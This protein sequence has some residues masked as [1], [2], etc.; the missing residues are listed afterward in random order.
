MTILTHV[1]IMAQTASN[2]R[3]S[4]AMGYPLNALNVWFLLGKIPLKWMMTGGTPISGNSH[5]M[6]FLALPPW[7]RGSEG[8]HLQ[9]R[10]LWTGCMCDARRGGSGAPGSRD[11][12]GDFEI[13]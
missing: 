1:Y 12:L 6:P 10:R 3:V 4:L 2:L 5:F 9:T 13:Q 11:G 8:L 7:S